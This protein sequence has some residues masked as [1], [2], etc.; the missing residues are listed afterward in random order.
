MLAAREQIANRV[1][2]L[3]RRRGTT[4]FQTVNDILEQAVRVEEMGLSLEEV[5]D[6]REAL[7]KAR[8]LGF[9]FTIER[10]LYEV[11]DLANY[12]AKDDVSEIWMDAGRWYG[13]YF[14]SRSKDGIG[15]F[16][17]AMELLSFGTYEFELRENRDGGISIACV[18][19]RFT[20]AYSGLFSLFIEGVLEAFGYRAVERDVSKS[21]IRL[22]FEKRR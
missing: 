11:V 2:E 7:E 16:R 19:E 6:K 15:E 12:R 10:L 8:R 9:A 18:G 14:V 1:A 13:K 20:P 5:V 17:E 4:V 22:R 3:A 21:I